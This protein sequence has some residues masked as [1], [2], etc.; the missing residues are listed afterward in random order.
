VDE[1]PVRPL[2]DHRHPGI[3]VLLVEGHI[4]RAREPVGAV[5]GPAIVRAREI[6]FTIGRP[7]PGIAGA[8]TASVFNAFGRC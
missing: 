2:L 8:E 7:W 6:F 3:E 1:P 5:E 4:E